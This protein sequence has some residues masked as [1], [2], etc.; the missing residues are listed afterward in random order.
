MLDK[1]K[2]AL[3]SIDKLSYVRPIKVISHYDADGITSAAIFSRALQRWNKKFSLQ[4]VKGLDEEFIKSLPEEG[5]IVF[6]DLASG[7]LQYLENK[8]TEIFI[9]DHHEITQKIPSNVTMINPLLENAEPISGAGVAYLAAKCISEHNKDLAHLAIIGMVGDMMDKNLGR[10]YDEIIKDAEAIVKRGLKIYPSTRSLDKA[11]EY[12][13]NPYIPGVTGSYR[14]VLEVLSD[15]RIPKINGKFKSLSELTEEEMR[16]LI[17]AIMLKTTGEDL[18]DKLIGNLF[19]VKLFNKLEDAREISAL[20]NACSR[21][22]HPSVALGFCLGDSSLKEEAAKIYIDYKQSLVSALKYVSETDKISGK[23]Y[24]I[25]NGRNNIKDTII[26][27]VASIISNSPTYSEGM[28]IVALAYNENK[29]KVSARIAGREGR[30][31]R[32]IL[33]Q[34]IAPLGG[35]VG[36]HPNAAGCLISKDHEDK[37]IEELKKVLEIEVVKV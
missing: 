13:S 36:G 24:T 32:E 12:S 4:I 10:A 8:K 22:D 1:I 16:S 31:V 23:N 21:M 3:N 9:F 19:L 33:T 17:T 27:T 7:S 20:I 14:G 35:E 25:I 2:L 26:G 37:F 5:P 6:L 18:S 28:I 29:I 15:A 30:N 34:A 11:L